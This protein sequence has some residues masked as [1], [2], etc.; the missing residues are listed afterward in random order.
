MVQQREE[1]KSHIW[2]RKREKNERE[3]ERE[4]RGGGERVVEGKREIGGRH[5]ETWLVPL[6]HGRNL[7][8]TFEGAATFSIT[9]P[10]LKG[11]FTTLSIRDNITTL[12]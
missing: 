8:L 3:R 9:T 11:L 6:F 1:Q 12:Q 4:S 10:S 2:V 5:K 7:G